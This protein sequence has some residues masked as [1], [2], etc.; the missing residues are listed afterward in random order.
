[1]QKKHKRDVQQNTSCVGCL[2]QPINDPKKR[3]LFFIFQNV[4]QLNKQSIDARLNCIE[5]F[6]SILSIFIQNES[7]C[8]KLNK[9]E[10]ECATHREIAWNK[11]RALEVFVI[12]IYCSSWFVLLTTKQLYV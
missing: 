11:D 5:V 4:F 1:M 6:L 9:L 12:F 3:G 10:E 8:M 2:Q 7:L